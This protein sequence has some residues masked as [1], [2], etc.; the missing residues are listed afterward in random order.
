MKTVFILIVWACVAVLIWAAVD[1][2]FNVV[3]KAYN[4]TCPSTTADGGCHCD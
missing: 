1:N 2:V 3:E 4:N